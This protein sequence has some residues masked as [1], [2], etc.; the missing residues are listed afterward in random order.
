MTPEMGCEEKRIHSFVKWLYAERGI[1]LPRRCLHQFSA[2]T[3]VED[4]ETLPGDLVFLNG[5]VCPSFASEARVSHVGVVAYHRLVVHATSNAKGGIAS[6]EISRWQRKNCWRGARRV[7]SVGRK[8]L[9]LE[10]PSHLEIETSDD[11]CWHL[12]EAIDWSN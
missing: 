3:P 2:G 5:S 1:W 9:T 4:D 11:V 12:L 6:A 8:I 10:I 7:I